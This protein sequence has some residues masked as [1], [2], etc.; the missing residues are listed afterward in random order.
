MK[1]STAASKL[2]GI[3]ALNV[4]TAYYQLFQCPWNLKVIFHK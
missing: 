2:M 4:I 1:L 3:K